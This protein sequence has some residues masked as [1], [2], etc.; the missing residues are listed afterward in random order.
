M[1]FIQRR[2]NAE[3]IPKRKGKLNSKDKKKI[4]S[5]IWVWT[6]QRNPPEMTEVILTNRLSFKGRKD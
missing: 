2:E 6:D 1:K 4:I 5:T 3:G